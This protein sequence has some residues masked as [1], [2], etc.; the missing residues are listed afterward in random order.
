MAIDEDADVIAGLEQGRPP[1]AEPG[2]AELV[3]V[4]REAGRLQFAREF[5]AAAGHDVVWLTYDTPVDED[6]VA[7]T[8]FVFDRAASLLPHMAPGALMLISSQ[9]PVGSTARLEKLCRDLK[10]PADIHFAY[11]PENLRLG[12]AIEVFTKPDRVV[13]GVRHLEDRERLARLYSP[14]TEHIEWMSVESAEMTKH[15]LNA[16]L[17]TS[18]VFINEIATICEQVGA[19]AAEV[20]RGLKSDARIGKRAYL[21][22]GGAYAGGTLARDVAFLREMAGRHNLTVPLLSGAKESNDLHRGWL[23]RRL[24]E[25]VGDLR[26]R[27]VA[28]LGL[29][30]KPGTDTLRRSSAVEVCRWLQ[31]QGASTQAF[32]PAI[33]SLPS[34][35]TPLIRLCASAK[36]ALHGCDAAL[37]TTEWPQLRELSADDVASRMRQAFILDPSGHLEST[38]R[39]DPRI[40]YF[41]VGQSNE[42]IR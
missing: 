11:S 3:Q 24:T 18:V 34:E 38:L 25:I 42:A 21:H 27:K 5:Q 9:L 12:K 1:V 29:T 22:P 32:D 4:Q 26:G 13:I 20:E 7:D 14:F 39:R 8:Q 37:V 23:R 40:S 36:D 10:F 30:Y 28:I 19:N 17:A 6:D 35:L 16:F 33:T 2:L 41:S 15:A 31:E